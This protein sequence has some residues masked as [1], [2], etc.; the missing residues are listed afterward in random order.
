[1]KKKNNILAITPIK[2]IESLVKNKKNN[3]SKSSTDTNILEI[4]RAL[5]NQ[6]GLK[7]KIQNKK[8]NSGWE[9]NFLLPQMSKIKPQF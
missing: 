3:S 2:H 1:M 8:N 6:L 4:E 9:V 7:V 5:E